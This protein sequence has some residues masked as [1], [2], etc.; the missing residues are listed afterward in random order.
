[1]KNIMGSITPVRTQHHSLSILQECGDAAQRE[2]WPLPQPLMN[3]H[4]FKIC[5]TLSK[6]VLTPDSIYKAW[7]FQQM[8][9]D[10]HR[11]VVLNLY[12]W[13]R[14]LPENRFCILMKKIFF[15]SARAQGAG[16]SPSTESWVKHILCDMMP[17]DHM[18]CTSYKVQIVCSCTSSNPGCNT[19]LSFQPDPFSSLQQLVPSSGTSEY[20]Q[21]SVKCAVAVCLWYKLWQGLAHPLS[22][23]WHK[24]FLC[25][26]STELTPASADTKNGRQSLSLTSAVHL[27]FHTSLSQVTTGQ[28]KCLCVRT[29]GWGQQEGNRTSLANSAVS[30]LEWLQVQ[31]HLCPPVAAF[32]WAEP[33]CGSESGL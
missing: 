33:R 20:I 15:K 27:S 8:T 30:T 31:C 6:Q 26:C 11:H 4:L 29:N 1:M 25:C 32:Y 16:D 17:W 13:K 21:T 14:S 10:T 2:I 9:S 18:S 7:L 12:I 23:G 3:F 22:H 24:G 5:L 28:S 19:G